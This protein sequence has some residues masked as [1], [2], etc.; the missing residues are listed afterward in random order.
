MKQVVSFEQA[1]E[2]IENGI[3]IKNTRDCYGKRKNRG[4]LHERSFCEL[5]AEKYWS[6]PTVGNLIEYIRNE[7]GLPDEP[8]SIFNYITNEIHS[9]PE[10]RAGMGQAELIDALVALILKIKK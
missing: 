9:I 10:Y 8:W 6:A 1:K 2:L 7:V 4:T 3:D 5:L